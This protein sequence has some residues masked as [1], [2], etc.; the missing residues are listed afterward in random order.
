MEKTGRAGRWGQV[1]W[2]R[3]EKGGE[4]GEFRR[5]EWEQAELEVE[6]GVDG[7]MDGDVRKLCCVVGR[8]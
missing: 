5:V 8:R 2:S 1:G 6:G 7:E 3:E 4:V